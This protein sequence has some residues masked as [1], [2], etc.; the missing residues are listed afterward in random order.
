MFDIRKQVPEL[1]FITE[2]Q[3]LFKITKSLIQDHLDLYHTP[4]I[5]ASEL[6]KAYNA[7]ENMPKIKNLATTIK[8]KGIQLADIEQYIKG[9][10]QE[11]RDICLAIFNEGIIT[12]AKKARDGTFFG[13]FMSQVFNPLNDK[14]GITAKDNEQPIDEEKWLTKYNEEIVKDNKDLVTPNALPGAQ[15]DMLP[16]DINPNAAV[17]VLQVDTINN[18]QSDIGEIKK[19][20]ETKFAPTTTL[21]DDVKKIL[22]AQVKDMKIDNTKQLD[23]I[24]KLLETK[25]TAI[26]KLF[27]KPKKKGN[28]AENM[29]FGELSAHFSDVID[30]SDKPNSGDIWVANRVLLDIKNYSLSVPVSQVTKIKDDILAHDNIYCGILVSMTS[31]I[32]KHNCF[33]VEKVSQNKYLLYAPKPDDIVMVVHCALAIANIASKTDNNDASTFIEFI[34]SELNGLIADYDNLVN[35]SGSL[36]D[37]ALG[38]YNHT[39]TI[40]NY[41]TSLK[42]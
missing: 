34:K 37:F 24:Q 28:I 33:D 36:H 20:I 12:E 1:C 29:I 39:V 31:G 6:I 8:L 16:K 25:F 10:N 17:P 7:N 40:N 23:S 22:D 19:I 4:F 2:D 38:Y 14:I 41:L 27:D 9:E 32:S 42:K 3:V 35:I 13:E 21:N 5:C 26:E 30:V 15:E 11:L 18:L